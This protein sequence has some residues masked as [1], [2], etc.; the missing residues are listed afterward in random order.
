MKILSVDKLSLSL[1]RNFLHSLIDERSVIYSGLF[2]AWF[3][4]FSVY[5]LLLSLLQRLDSIFWSLKTTWRRSLSKY[6]F[7]VA[8]FRS[9]CWTYPC[10]SWLFDFI[11][12]FLRCFI[13]Y[14]ILW[15]PSLSFIVLL[16]SVVL[17]NLLGLI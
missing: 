9:T 8:S 17:S 15:R 4:W 5:M 16:V 10:F 12:H 14:D 7:T 1:S 11:F 13:R 6:L 2:F 3:V